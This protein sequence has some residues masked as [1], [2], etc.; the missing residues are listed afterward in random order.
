M[1]VPGQL[2]NQVLALLVSGPAT[3]AQLVE[4]L[5]ISRSALGRVL[6]PLFACNAITYQVDP[7]APAR[8]RPVERLFLTQNVAYGIGIDIARN[9]CSAVMLD[10]RGQ[11]LACAGFITPEFPGWTQSM[12]RICNELMSEAKAKNINLSYLQ[13]AGVGLPLPINKELHDNVSQGLRNYWDCPFSIRNVIEM[14]ALGE[15]YWYPD[16]NRQPGSQ[17]YVRVSGG[18]SCCYLGKVEGQTAWIL[19]GELGHLRNHEDERPCY[20]G[21]KGCVELSTSVPALCASAGVT[22]VTELARNHKNGDVTTVRVMEKFV[23]LMV[24]AIATSSMFYQPSVVTLGGELIDT[25]PDLVTRI[26]QSFHNL[27]LPIHARPLTFRPAN[28]TAEQAALG[29]AAAV[30]QPLNSPDGIEL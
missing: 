21:G 9:H 23:N 22:T 15:D 25:M 2:E 19:V 20:C 12:D 30:F 5:G 10:R 14:A 24:H 11:E 27:P 16:P 18:V 29:A 26:A 13:G 7:A 8:G 4:H 17:L 6:A 1:P 3:R 28:I